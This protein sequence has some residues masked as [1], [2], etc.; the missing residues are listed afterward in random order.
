MRWCCF[1]VDLEARH[2]RYINDEEWP[3]KAVAVLAADQCTV[4]FD[5]STCALCAAHGIAPE[6]QSVAYN[7]AELILI[8]VEAG[9][10]LAMHKLEDLTLVGATAEDLRDAER[11]GWKRFHAFWRYSVLGTG[12]RPSWLPA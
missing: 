11:F 6:W 8:R 12:G 10:V 2:T 9:G 1:A 3:T 5:C 4:K 7:S